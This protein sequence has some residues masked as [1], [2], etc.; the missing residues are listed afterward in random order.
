[1]YCTASGTSIGGRYILQFT[2]P[3]RDSIVSA[4]FKCYVSDM[5]EWVDPNSNHRKFGTVIRRSVLDISGEHEVMP[6]FNLAP[7]ELS[8]MIA[9]MLDKV[10]KMNMDLIEYL[11]ARDDLR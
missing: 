3:Q 1:M 2:N 6:L 11:G 8:G 7:F 10:A 4:S 9:W 5:S